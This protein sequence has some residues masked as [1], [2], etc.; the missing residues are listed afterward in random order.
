MNVIGVVVG[1]IIVTVESAWIAVAR[2]REPTGPDTHTVSR[3]A[4]RASVTG[5]GSVSR[6]DS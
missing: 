4:L 6:T 5:G 1:S 2:I 3:S